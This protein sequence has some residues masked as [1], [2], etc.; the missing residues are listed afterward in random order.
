MSA[1]ATRDAIQTTGLTKRFGRT[2]ALDQL[3]LT[4]EAGEVFGFLGPN[5]AGKSTTIRLLLG[6]LRPTAGQAWIFGDAAADAAAAH[7]NLAYVPADVA[8]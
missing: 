6:H 2:L 7:R 5:G 3:N 8:L 4:L 1:L